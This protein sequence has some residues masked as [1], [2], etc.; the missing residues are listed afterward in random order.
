MEREIT[1]EQFLS[2]DIPTR[3]RVLKEIAKGPIK[4]RG[5]V[6]ERNI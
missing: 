2:Y 6:N 4:Y 1:K 5:D 3:L